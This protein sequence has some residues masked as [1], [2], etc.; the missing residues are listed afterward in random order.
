MSAYII[1]KHNRNTDL[2][3]NEDVSLSLLI[4]IKLQD[5]I[6]FDVS[7]KCDQSQKLVIDNDNINALKNCTNHKKYLNSSKKTE[8]NMSA[9]LCKWRHLRKYFLLIDNFKRK[10]INI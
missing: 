3:E 10:L 4:H 2:L 5:W 8:K 9:L 6:A 7:H 1:D